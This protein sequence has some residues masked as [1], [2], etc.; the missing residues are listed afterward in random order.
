M[1]GY[2]NQLLWV[3]LTESVIE[4]RELNNADARQYIGGSGLATRILY[5]E[6]DRQTHPLGPG[7]VLIFMT[8]PFTATPAL[9]SSR[10]S[11]VS[12][13]PL[14][15]IY[16]EAS[17]G[18]SWGVMLKRSGFDGVIIKGIAPRPVYLWIS[19]GIAELR[20]ADHIWGQDTFKTDSVLKAET[21]AKAAISCIGPAG[22]KTVLIA[23]IVND[24]KHART[25]AR[26]GLGA[27]M[28]S[29]NLKAIAVHGNQRVEIHDRDQLKASIARIAKKVRDRTKGLNMLGTLGAVALNEEFGSLPIQNWRHTG[30]WKEGAKKI[31]GATVLKTYGTGKYYCK[32]CIIGC[33]KNMRITEG[34]FMGEQQAAPEYETLSLMGAN[35][36][37]DDPEVIA[38]ANDLCNRYGIDTM[39][40]AGAIAFG[41]EAYEKGIISQENTEGIVLEWGN[42]DALLKVIQQI[43]EKRG[44]GKLLAS[45][46]KHAAMVLGAKAEEFAIHVKGLELP[47][48]DPRVYSAGALNL[49]T[50]ARG[51]CHLS[52]C[53]HSFER[54]LSAPEIGI[55]EPMDPKTKEGKGIATA[56]TQDYMGMLDALTTCKFMPFGG[57]G[58]SDYA[59]WYRHIT[60]EPMDVESFMECGERIFNLKRLY[61]TECG[62]SRNDDALPARMLKRKNREG[63]ASATIPLDE[64][65]DEYYAYRGWSKEGIPTKKKMNDLGITLR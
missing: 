2:M 65:L 54:V 17:S 32:S 19:E 58:I 36:M 10:Y 45:G 20:S 21:N 48:H 5:E 38:K 64:M 4:S 28:G 13:S 41:M 53:S 11:V 15:G 43:G 59:K 44:I 40:A 27:V 8:G 3:N 33:G 14:T 42:G 50:S 37:I 55:P 52:G 61:N 18:G 6:T 39:S 1:K 34:T 25:A 60:G 23:A 31:T 7:N 35:C 24:G 51:A 30:R 49:A 47:A 12:K 22:E 16:G 62:I 63:Y 29:K 9:S 26:C 46:T 56:K 57:V